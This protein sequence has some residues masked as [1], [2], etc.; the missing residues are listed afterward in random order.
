MIVSKWKFITKKSRLAKKC[1]KNAT[2]SKNLYQQNRKTKMKY[3]QK[4]AFYHQIFKNEQI[5]TD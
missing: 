3:N 2:E 1:N 5:Q 4:M